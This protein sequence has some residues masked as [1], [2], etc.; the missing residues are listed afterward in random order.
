[1]DLFADFLSLPGFQKNKKMSRVINFLDLRV[2]V[3]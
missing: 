3:E 2:G 1:M